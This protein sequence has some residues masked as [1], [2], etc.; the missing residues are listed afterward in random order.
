MDFTYTEEQEM[1]RKMAREFLEKECTE[2]FIRAMEKDARGYSPDLWKKIAE[3]GWLGLVIPEKYGG[4]EGS[5]TDM[6]VL[7]EE[8]GRSMFPSPH[9][10]TAVLCGMTIL[11]AGSEEQKAAYL[12]KIV[13]GDCVMA[14]A[15]TEPETSWNGRAWDPDG[16]TM[17]ARQDGDDYTLSGTKLF[18]HDAN[19]AD[20]LLVVAR[21][22]ATRNPANGVTLFLVG[23]K[24]PGIKCTLLQ[25]IA[26]DK[27]CEVVFKNV[28][29][30]KKNIV[31]QIHGGWPPLAQVLKIGAVILSAQMLGAAQKLLELTVDY[32]KTRVQF[33]MPI[34]INQYI[35]EHCVNLYADMDGIKW[36]TYYA[37]WKLTKGDPA[38]FEA[39]V[40]KGW[41]SDAFERITWCAHQVFAGIGYTVNDGLVPLFSRRGKVLQ[42]YLG[43]SAFHKEKIVEQLEK[44]PKPERPQG[45]PLGLWDNDEEIVIPHWYEP[46]AAQ[47]KPSA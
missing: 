31:G 3:L 38:D 36:S 7:Y 15:L 10:S 9:F 41:A 20:Y 2:R 13:N 43:D 45:P 24:D 19:S 44:W 4:T 23:A 14:L 33:D 46:F 11:S 29:V 12:R 17:R 6:C 40:A 1:L 22:R 27:Q 42:L 35:Q 34:G 47:S 16:V 30:N 28:R 32:A 18:V 25:T 37:A 21:T 26:G 8:F 39:A 5:I